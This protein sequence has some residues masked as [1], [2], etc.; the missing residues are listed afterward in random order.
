MWHGIWRGY[1]VLNGWFEGEIRVG[2]KR[3]K[4]L[5]YKGLYDMGY[6]SIYDIFLG[7]NLYNMDF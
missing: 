2:F 1:E 5:M 4:V 7:L 3:G 6:D